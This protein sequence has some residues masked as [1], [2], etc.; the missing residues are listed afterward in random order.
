M[1]QAQSSGGGVQ[2]VALEILN[3]TGRVP[4]PA[5]LVIFA[6][7]GSEDP[8]TYRHLEIMAPWLLQRGMELV[9][10]KGCGRGHKRY[11][12][13]LYE[14]I[15][16]ESTAIPVRGFRGL[17]RRQCTRDW[18][19]DQVRRVLRERGAGKGK[20]AVVQLG[21]SY[22]EIH[23]MKD[24]PVA[25]VQHRFPL[26]ELHLTREDCRQITRDEGLPV[27]PRSRCY[28]CP[29]QPVGSWQR[30]A[31]EQP[32][33]F[34]AAARL[35]DTII[36]R[37]IARGSGPVF[38]SSRLRPLREAF[39]TQQLAMPMSGDGEEDELCGGYCFT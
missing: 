21:I 10:R 13:P 3:A 30:L 22:D 15:M 17:G 28:F 18:K 20:P 1:I 34:E 29:L 4:D 37:A 16:T 27:P 14:Y 2:S 33:L 9:V 36:M 32:E 26:V 6:D 31:S 35:E 24:S 25:W 23:R 8:G 38:L 19:V 39:S 7:P 12:I 11:G 5:H